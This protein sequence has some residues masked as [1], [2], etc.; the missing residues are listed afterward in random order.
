MHKPNYIMIN[1][2]NQETLLFSAS[3]NNLLEDH[4]TQEVNWVLEILRWRLR[5][6]FDDMGEDHI[7]IK[8]PSLDGKPSLFSDLV[9]YYSLTPIQ[10]IILALALTPVVAPVELYHTVYESDTYDCLAY[11]GNLE[12]NPGL[13]FPKA[14][15][16]LFLLHGTAIEK[17]VETMAE[18]MNH[19]LFLLN[20]LTLTTH[21]G[22]ISEGNLRIEHNLIDYLAGKIQIDQLN[23]RPL[24]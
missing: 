3:K 20:H 17:K 23:E 15:T 6:E 24:V 14:S 1:Q 13:F 5:K 7:E 4:L 8:I 12:N 21:S 9:I 2:N 18:I 22:A 10:R 19:P 11:G 16:L